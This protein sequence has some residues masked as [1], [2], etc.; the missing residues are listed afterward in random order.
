MDLL[1]ALYTN[2]TKSA[3]PHL[4]VIF[5]ILQSFGLNIVNVTHV[6][7]EIKYEYTMQLRCVNIKHFILINRT[8]NCIILKR[9][10]VSL[11]ARATN[12][13]HNQRGYIVGIIQN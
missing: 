1:H 10:V 7:I 11:R 6:T 5:I 12:D 8:T 4:H 2:M 13:V 9:I 3:M